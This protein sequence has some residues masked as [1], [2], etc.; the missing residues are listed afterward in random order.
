MA[1]VQERQDPHLRWSQ[2]P[3]RPWRRPGSADSR[4]GA[5]W[6][7]HYGMVYSNPIGFRLQTIGFKT[8]LL[9]AAFVAQEVMAAA[10]WTDLKGRDVMGPP[11]VTL[12]N[13]QFAT[14]NVAH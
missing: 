3:P 12:G 5:T 9:V 4:V 7:V 10:L 11:V 13:Y 6:G 1:K 8:Y 14:R 2:A